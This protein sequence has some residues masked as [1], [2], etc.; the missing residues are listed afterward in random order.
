MILSGGFQSADHLALLK[1]ISGLRSFSASPNEL[2]IN[3]QTRTD[4]NLWRDLLLTTQS[5]SGAF[6]RSADYE[7]TRRVA[8]IR[9]S[10][11]VNITIPDGP[12]N[13]LSLAELVKEWPFSLAVFR[14]SFQKQWIAADYPRWGFGRSMIDHGWGCAFRGVGHDRLVSRRWLDFGPW[15]VIRRPNDTTFIQFHD[16]EITD[17]AAAYA[18]AA[19]GHE[20]MGI[21]GRGGYI[22]W[23][24][25]NLLTGAATINN[26]YYPEK[27]LREIVVGPGNEVT[28]G[29]MICQCA[30]R[31]QHRLTR[32]ASGRIDTIAY[33]FMDRGDAEAH[34]HELWLREL[35]CWY[36]DA[37]G[38]HRLDDNYQPTP[39]P[40]AWVT[41]LVA[42]ERATGQ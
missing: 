31:L 35:Q 21:A 17:P 11:L 22:A 6:W 4:F 39:T 1:S 40:P 26:F 30:V 34:L 5:S 27:Q 9:T 10:E 16:L 38:K 33:I 8:Y 7:I 25:E 37:S 32:P 14:S 42:R 13:V 3:N 19:P 18:Q 20:R 36:V 2:D 28:Q 41:A 23:H 15:R 24:F 29:Q 12:K